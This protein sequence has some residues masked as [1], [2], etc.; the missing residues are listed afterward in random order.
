MTTRNFISVE[1]DKD[2]FDKFQK[3]LEKEAASMI[4]EIGTSLQNSVRSEISKAGLVDT[5]NFI[6]SVQ[7]DIKRNDGSAMAVVGT[8]AL[9]ALPLEMGLKK[10]FY[11]SKDMI[12][13]IALWAQ[14]KLH[15]SAGEAK[16]AAGGIAWNIARK[17]VSQGFPR[18]FGKEGARVFEKGFSNVVARVPSIIERYVRRAAALTEPQV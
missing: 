15:L 1:L 9:Y 4:G 17:G 7:L 13:A 10:T 14:R 6:R 5:A 8:N 3:N 12:Q 2:L 16:K 11:P 18:R